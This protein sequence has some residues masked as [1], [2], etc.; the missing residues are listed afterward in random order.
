MK[1][2]LV[3]GTGKKGS[4]GVGGPPEHLELVRPHGVVVHPSGAIYVSDSENNRVLR[5]ER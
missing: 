2:A 1:I 3:A 5:I 4:G